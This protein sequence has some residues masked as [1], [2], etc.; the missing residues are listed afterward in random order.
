MLAPKELLEI[1]P[2][3][4]SPII[5][6]GG[7]TVAESAVIVEY[8]IK[9]YG[10][11]RFT[12][13]ALDEA[14]QLEDTYFLHF[15]E[16]SFM[17]PLVMKHIFN[18][19]QTNSPFFIRPIVSAIA[20]QV[21]KSSIDP[22]VKRMFGLLDETL[23]KDGGRKWIIGMDE[24]TGADFMLSFPLEAAVNGGRMP[25]DL[26]SQT[27]KDYVARIQTRPAYI[28]ALEKGPKYSY[29]PKEKL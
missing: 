6:D 10:N 5:T 4:K 29:G 2:L 12:A 23:S 3:G 24:P 13:P 16:G 15:A 9:K 7:L 27:L 14:K 17:P 28:R 25:E 19:V 11:G 21:E 26:I 22:N 1:Y 18:A 8:L 20:G